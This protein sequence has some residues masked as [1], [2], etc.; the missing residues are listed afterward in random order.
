MIFLNCNVEKQVWECTKY[1]AVFVHLSKFSCTITAGNAVLF[2]FQAIV[3]TLK[4]VAY[5]CLLLGLYIFICALMG[6][7]AY[8]Y[9]VKVNNLDDVECVTKGSAAWD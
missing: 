7:E 5:F 8:A 9:N 1:R 2:I 6:L 3:E 4:D